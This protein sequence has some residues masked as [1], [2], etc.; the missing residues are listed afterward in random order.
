[1]NILVEAGGF[2]GVDVGRLQAAVAHTLEIEARDAVEI[3]LT[4]LDDD[5]IRE[6]NRRYL[7]H[8]RPT[9]V[10]SF[11]LGAP[12]DLVGDV[13][14]GVDQARRQAEEHGVPVAEELLRLAIH[15]TLH[16]LGHDHPEGEDRYVSPMFERQE[17]ILRTL[18][19]SDPA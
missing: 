14:L 9:D 2:G 19:D 5:E 11:T 4:L 17:H 16:V 1:V 18:L 7:G 12:D 6:L 15:G 13:Y 3:S 10:I 8:D